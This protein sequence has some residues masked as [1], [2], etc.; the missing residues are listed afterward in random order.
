MAMKS[1]MLTSVA[2]ALLLAAAPVAAQDAAAAGAPPVAEIEHKGPH[3]DRAEKW[4]E[5]HK[6]MKDMSPEEREAFIE[7][8]RAD[9]RAKMEARINA[10]PPEEQ[11]A[12]RDKMIEMEARREAMHQELMAM[13]PEERRAKMKEIQAKM[14]ERRASHPEGGD[15]GPPV[16]R[17]QEAE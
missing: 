12:A 3:G 4:R 16:S 13:P 5:D 1:L 14:K 2:A 11:A 10:L 15:K 17:P 6:R 7:K 9:R 8:R